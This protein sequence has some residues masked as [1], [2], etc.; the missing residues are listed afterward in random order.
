MSSDKVVQEIGHIKE[1]LV[2]K[3]LLNDMQDEKY[4]FNTECRMFK[5][6]FPFLLSTSSCNENHVNS[7]TTHLFKARSLFQKCHFASRKSKRAIL[8]LEDIHEQ[9]Y[10][11]CQNQSM[12]LDYNHL[13]LVLE[14]LARFHALS[15]AG[16]MKKPLEFYLKMA[17]KIVKKKPVTTKQKDAELLYAHAYFQ[18]LQFSA[19]QPVEEFAKRYLEPKYFS[20]VQNLN[21]LLENVV[22][23]ITS[24]LRP[25]EPLSVLCHGNLVFNK[26]YFKYD[27]DNI[28]ISVKFIDFQNVHYASPAVDLS[29]FLFLNTS[30]ELRE[31]HWND[32][33]TT[34]HTILIDSV[35]EF[36]GCLKENQSSEFSLN[37]FKEEFSKHALYGYVFTS[38]YVISSSLKCNDVLEFF[39]EGTPSRENVDRYIEENFKVQNEPVINR[40][41][42][43][44]RELLEYNLLPPLRKDCVD[45]LTV[46]K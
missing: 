16:K 26:I 35:A 29:V 2:V 15:Y 21:F 38:G 44:V 3:K 23:L 10:R 22:E 9:G 5:D 40:L 36:V 37:A 1:K 32:L 14:G 20:G 27:S 43:I 17:N 33:F 4:L 34:Y 41:M 42:A 19:I 6:I 25:S 45:E 39:R 11:V 13:K 28:P 18:A 8:V 24:S 46:E 31:K 7:S 12:T 30:S